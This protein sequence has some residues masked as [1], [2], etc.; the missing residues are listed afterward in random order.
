M[1]GWPA[2]LLPGAL[3][4]PVLNAA[5]GGGTQTLIWQLQTTDWTGQSP[6]F[7]LLVVG[8]NNLGKPTCE[9]VLGVE[10]AI[11][12]S[13]HTFPTARIIYVSILPRGN[14]MRDWE[15][16]IEAI[17]AELMAASAGKYLF[18]D[19][20]NAFLCNHKTPCALFKEG[21]LHPSLAG[22]RVLTQKLHEIVLLGSQ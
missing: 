12:A 13:H 21:D 17:N 18:V 19:A 6:R 10:A 2:S 3:G 22:Y 9:V 4:G 15:S 11:T 5:I 16:K 7:V 14:N 1:F 8:T 20:H